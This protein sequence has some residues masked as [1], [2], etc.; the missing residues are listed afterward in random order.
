MEVETK[1]GPGSREDTGS[2][3]R[4]V[5]LKPTLANKINNTANIMRNEHTLNRETP[6]APNCCRRIRLNR[7]SRVL[8]DVVAS[9]L[10]F[11]FNPFVAGVVIAIV[12]H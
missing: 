10:S 7:S 8:L 1:A 12:V 9:R 6:F 5:A 2:L 4:I 11:V 3:E